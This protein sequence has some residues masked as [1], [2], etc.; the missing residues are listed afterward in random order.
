MVVFTKFIEKGQKL[1]FVISDED[2]SVINSLRR[3]ILSEIPTVAFYFD[4]YDQ[5]RADIVIHKNTGVLHN[6]FISHR[7]SLIPLYFDLLEIQGFDPNRYK[8]VLKKKN[9]GTDTVLVTT[10]DFD[11]FENG[12]KLPDAFREHVFPM[13]KVTKDHILITKLRANMYD[14]AHGEEI[15][16]ECTASVGT[17]QEHARWCAVSQCSFFNSIDLA[18]EQKAFEELMSSAKTP[19]ERK[20]LQSRFESIDKYRHFKTDEYDEPNSFDFSIQSECGMSPREIFGK[21]IDILTD[22]VKMFKENI[23][24][25]T[26]TELANCVQFEI[27]NEN[28]TLLNVLQCLIYNR[29]FRSPNNPIAYIGYYQSH[30]LDKT[31]FLK[32]R[33]E[34]PDIDPKEFLA[35]ECGYIIDHLVNVKDTFVKSN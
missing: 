28:F 5:E 33:F 21:A 11:I 24:Q 31:M 27:K 2:L 13:C 8:F 7:V 12:K 18:K 4:A 3:I 34:N 26:M 16:L 14:P 29:C 17:G 23:S 32:I 1:S 10:K 22:K 25:I 35:Q 9:T 19:E 20:R 6:E 30:P 15:D